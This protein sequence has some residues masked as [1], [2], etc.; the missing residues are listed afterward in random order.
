MPV[1]EVRLYRDNKGK[2]PAL[3]WLRGLPRTVQEKFN[4]RIEKLRELG[5]ELRRPLAAYLRDGIYELRVKHRHDQYRMLYFFHRQEAV[6]LSHGLKKKER[7]VKDVEINLAVSNKR[8]YC[9]NPEVH[10][11]WLRE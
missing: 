7:K 4:T 6:I 3:D 8:K 9:S 1:T 10:T 2:V 5:H 11:A